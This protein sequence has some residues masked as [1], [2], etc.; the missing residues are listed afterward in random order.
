M[1]GR[2]AD[3][4]TFWKIALAAA[5]VTWGFSFF[6]VKDIVET[7]P[8]FELLAIRF[9]SSAVIMLVLFFKDILANVKKQTVLVGLAMG[10]VEWAAFSA[11]T[12]GIAETTAGKSAFLT[13]TYCVLVPFVSHFMSGEKLT[14]YNVGAAFM[15]LAGIALVALDSAELN[16]GDALTLV[17]A[18]LFA[19]Q[20]AMAAKYGRNLDVNAMTFWMFVAMGALSL[21]SCFLFEEPLALS[22]FDATTW[23]AL[24]FLSAICTCLLMLIQNKG[25]AMV[26]AS[27][28]ALLL[29]LESP[30]GVF[31][32][33]LMT[34]ETLTV[35]LVVGFV[36]IFLAIVVSETHLSFL[37]RSSE[38]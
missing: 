33:V 24:A 34:G 36:L 32:S 18:V 12:L 11:Q 8:T 6:V 25:L 28:G 4:Q 21:A 10:L 29:S 27:S 15:C 2:L 5:A 30:S 1:A 31:F 16:V 9:G 23:L 26:P 37:K 17:G 13:G 7:L 20:I 14:R 38:D 35:R 3:S 19:L 22:S